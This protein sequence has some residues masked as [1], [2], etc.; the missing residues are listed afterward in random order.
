MLYEIKIW[1]YKIILVIIYFNTNPST[2]SVE[3]EKIESQLNSWLEILLGM[4]RY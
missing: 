1:L 4:S 2:P 3:Q